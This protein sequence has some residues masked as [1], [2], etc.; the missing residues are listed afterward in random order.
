[1]GM[2]RTHWLLCGADDFSVAS[3]YVRTFFKKSLLIHYDVI[4]AVAGDSCS[5]AEERFWLALEEGLAAN[6]R[7]L[8]EFV[9]DLRGEDCNSLDDLITLPR[10]YASKML[11]IIAHLLDGFIGI[12]S[13]LYNLVEDSHSLSDGLREVIR[14]APDRYWLVRVEASFKSSATASIIHQQQK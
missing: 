3:S 9:D 11:H 13:V 6:R 4:E 2:T 8:A 7:V 14:Q 5:A 1:M 12:D 10:G